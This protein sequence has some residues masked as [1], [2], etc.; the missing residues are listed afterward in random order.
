MVN[1]WPFSNVAE[2][3]GWYIFLFNVIAAAFIIFYERQE[4]EKTISW[5]LV[6]FALP[7]IGFFLYLLLGRDR[8]KRRFR[9]KT[10]HD[11]CLANAPRLDLDPRALEQARL[12]PEQLGFLQLGYATDCLL[13]SFDNRVEILTNGEQK[14]ETLIRDIQAAR[15]HVHLEYFIWQKDEIGRW[16]ESLLMEKAR[17]GVEVRILLDGLGSWRISRRDLRRWHEAGIQA[18]YF[19]PVSKWSLLHINYRDHRK[20]AVIDGRIA[21]VG[22]FNVGDNY[23]GKGPL[24]PW[25]DTHL[26]I[27]GSAVHD[28]QSVFLGDWEFS[29]DQA[30]NGPAYFPPS[31]RPGNQIVQINASGPD[32]P[33]PSVRFIYF[34]MIAAAR[35]KIRLT[36]PYFIPDQS[37]TM[38]LQSAALSG[39]D[40]R[41]IT[42]G[43]P[44]HPPVIWAGRTFMRQLIEAGVRFYEYQNG[45]I[46]SKVLTV[47]GQAASVGTANFDKRSLD[48]DF[49]VNA[50]LVGSEITGELDC[51]F[52]IDVAHSRPVTLEE[53]LNRPLGTRIRESLA[54]LASPLF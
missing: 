13:P 51:Q 15:H 24:G 3:V 34:R 46:H 44:D 9:S 37:L 50:L 52:D 40:V 18:T 35:Q 16:L 36:T 30:V 8:R 45:F 19:F 32:T 49:E 2:A 20:I 25:R 12:T 14:F 48:L 31:D 27:R 29:T 10:I 28:L 23:L 6:L 53:L 1:V 39:V 54:R 43:V 5:L 42:P 26:R 4:P 41:I 7:G 22:G 21:F 33:W 17:E 47:D 11:R 38:A